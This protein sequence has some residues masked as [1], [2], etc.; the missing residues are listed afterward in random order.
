MT[1][2]KEPSDYRSQKY[3]VENG[4]AVT[5]RKNCAIGLSLCLHPA[6]CRK[7]EGGGGIIFQRHQIIVL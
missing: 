6:S 3:N 5:L 1:I 4:T 7:R 2:W